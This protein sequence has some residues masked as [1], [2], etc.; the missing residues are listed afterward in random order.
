MVVHELGKHI[1]VALLSM[2]MQLDQLAASAAGFLLEH[3]RVVA[4][5]PACPPTAL[6]GSN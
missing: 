2:Q 6:Q 1:P 3:L 5:E 4:S